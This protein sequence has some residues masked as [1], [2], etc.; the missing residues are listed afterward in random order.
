MYT[1]F[2]QMKVLSIPRALYQVQPDIQ[3]A[4][5]SASRLENEFKKQ[6]MAEAESTPLVVEDCQTLF[7]ASSTES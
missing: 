5:S 2:L 3:T 7:A 6:L 4:V 1:T